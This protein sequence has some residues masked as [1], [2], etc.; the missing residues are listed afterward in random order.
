[1]NLYLEA[2]VR[3]KLPDRDNNNFFSLRFHGRNAWNEFK[4]DLKTIFRNYNIKFQYSEKSPAFY[5]RYKSNKIDVKVTWEED[6]L[7]FNLEAELN[8]DQENLNGCVEIY[9]LLILF[10]GKLIAGTEPYHW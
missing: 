2:G 7:L 4:E 9:D 1:M 3:L 8:L 6:S 10:S 5:V